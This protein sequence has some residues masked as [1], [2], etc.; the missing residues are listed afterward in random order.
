MVRGAFVRH[1]EG[2]HA[3]DRVLE[4]RLARGGV[5]LLPFT[6]PCGW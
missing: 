6:G 1:A 4:D 5:P 3:G 2:H